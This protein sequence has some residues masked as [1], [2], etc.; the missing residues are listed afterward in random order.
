MMTKLAALVFVVAT[1][2]ASTTDGDFH[3]SGRVAD[4]RVTH[5]IAINTADGSR[6]IVSKLWDD[7]FQIAMK[8]GGQ[9]LLAFADIT[10]PGRDMLVGTLQA[11]DLDALAPQDAGELDLGKISFAEGRAHSS[12]SFDDIAAALGLDATDAR[13]L[14]LRDDLALRFSNVDVDGNGALEASAPILNVEGQYTTTLTLDNLVEG[15]FA[16]ARVKYLS[17]TVSA[18]VPSRMNMMMATGTMMF[19]Q[20]FFGSALGPNTPMVEPFTQIGAPHIK[21]GEKAGSRVIG[22]TARAG[23]DVPRGAYELDFANGSLTYTHV[24]PPS[25]AVLESAQSYSVPFLHIK[26]N[27]LGCRFNCAI[28]ALELNW[29][30]MTATGWKPTSDRAAHVDLIVRRNGKDTYLAADLT[31]GAIQWEDI[32]VTNTGITDYELAY[33]STANI[34]YVAVSY[35]S[36]LGMRMTNQLTNPACF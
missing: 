19:E 3:V 4:S 10:K 1:G 27:A 34:C 14:G 12:A 13:E 20:P 5:V 33:F 7:S 17:T 18:S 16:D 6:E 36:E 30:T 28:D 32:N 15:K 24:L 23:F 2:C 22:L 8:P 26:P 35:E 29:N 25:A 9:Y 11:N 31:S 21:L